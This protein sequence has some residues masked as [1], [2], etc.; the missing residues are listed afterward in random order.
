MTMTER[1]MLLFIGACVGFVFGY[2]VKSLRC[3]QADLEEPSMRR[4]IKKF[5]NDKGLIRYPLLLDI[6]LFL[7]VALT[8]Y[9]AVQSQFASNRS[10]DAVKKV[11]TSAVVSCQ[12]A[13]ETREAN[14]ALWNFVID[15]S[16]AGQKKTDEKTIK[17]LQD[18]RAWV[19]KVYQDHDCNDLDKKYPIPDPPPIIPHP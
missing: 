14:L 3:I 7:T 12:N 15:L 18:I 13:N 10:D 16:V 17:Y 1:I 9:A 19:G 4:A 5:H 11:S 6:A 2:I 8:V